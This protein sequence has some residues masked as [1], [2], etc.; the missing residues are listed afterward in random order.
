M[1]NIAIVV[2]IQ[3]RSSHL[4][5]QVLDFIIFYPGWWFEPL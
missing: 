5:A 3:P 2:E 1:K 4:I